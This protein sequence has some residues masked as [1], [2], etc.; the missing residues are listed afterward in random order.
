MWLKVDDAF[1]RHPKVHAAADQ[2]GGKNPVGRVA[3]VWLECGLWAAGSLSD[4]FVPNRELARLITDER[5]KEVLQALASAGLVRAEEAGIR[6]H[7]WEDHNPLAEDVKEKKDRERERKREERK[8]KRS[9]RNTDGVRADIYKDGARTSDGTSEVCPQGQLDGIREDSARTSD[10][11]SDG[12]SAGSPE[13]SRARDPVPSR[14]HEDQNRKPTDAAAPA[15]A[16][17]VA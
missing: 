1:L 10:G 12:T 6:L 14:P 3:A 9:G 5:P 4:G 16:R 8:K 17:R 2:L 11:M 13:R 7:D 15:G